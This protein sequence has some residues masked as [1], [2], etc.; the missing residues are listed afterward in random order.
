M[1]CTCPASQA[2]V[3]QHWPTLPASE[4]WRQYWLQ[5]EA[6]VTISEAHYPGCPLR[7]SADERHARL[8]ASA[9]G[10]QREDYRGPAPDGVGWPD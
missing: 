10:E 4:Q 8:Y 6:R 3:D 2:D 7:E 9:Y 1:V 5:G